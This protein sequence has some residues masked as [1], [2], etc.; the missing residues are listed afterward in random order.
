MTA[1][2]DNFPISTKTRRRWDEFVAAN[3]VAAESGKSENH[4][5]ALWEQSI[6]AARTCRQYPGLVDELPA[7]T[8]QHTIDYLGALEQLTAHIEEEDEFRQKL[9]EFRNKHY[10]FICWKD[11]V[12]EADIYG[13]LKE[14]SALADACL[15]VTE[16]WYRLKLTEKFGQPQTAGGEAAHLVIIGLGKLGGQELNFSS[17]IDIMFCFSE[18]G[19]TNGPRS[20]SNQEFFLK[21]AQQIIKALSD[22]SLG[23]FVFRVDCRL[24]PFGESGPLAVNFNYLEDYFHTHGREWERYAFIKARVIVG[25]AKDREQFNNII[26]GFVYRRYIDF[27][28]INTLREMKDMIA[29][30]VLKKGYAGNIKLG[31][32]GIREIEFIVQFFQL[33]H[34]G[35]NPRM[36]TRSLVEAYQEVASAGY[37]DKEDVNK[38]IQAYGFHRRVEN[39]LQMRNDEQ[40]HLLPVNEDAL[41]LLAYSMAYEDVEEFKQDLSIHTNQVSLLFSQIRSDTDKAMPEKNAYVQCWDALTAGDEDRDVDVSSFGDAIDIKHVC[42]KLQQLLGSAAYRAQDKVS[43]Q[44]LKQFMPVFLTCLQESDSPAMVMDRLNM[45]LQNILRRSA[46]LVLLYENKKVLRQLI[47]VAASSPWIASHITS[48]PLLMDDLLI[49]TEGDY[50]LSREEIEQ[51]FNNEVLRHSNLEY[52]AI[53]E[54]VRF[55]KHAHE[56]NVAC[57]DV[58]GLLPVMKVSDQL[59]WIAEVIVDGCVKYLEET[60]YPDI[61]G[62]LAVIAFGKLGGI[63]LSYGSDLDLVYISNNPQESSYPE[64]AKVPYVVRV[65]KFA[66]KLTQMLALQTV[67]GQLYEVDTRLRPDGV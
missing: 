52:D 25:T 46:Y 6:F 16:Q 50:H 54:R 64:D 58:Q 14:L 8:E 56:L 44:R 42:E 2:A 51:R 17:D 15:R 37:L 32:G 29:Q 45:L 4:M 22:I 9:R 40:T 57:A 55:F 47:S 28:V 61:K 39:R 20:I 48:Y 66:Q 53:L 67:S 3:Q 7:I 63:E 21:L 11:L 13:I 19:N 60:F 24:R 43:R 30:Q 49:N 41:Q 31:A 65:T 33:V 10:L 23:G 27:G 34:G 38:L 59:T 35:I 12:L 62:N 18:S 26:S 5:L 1:I 36:Q